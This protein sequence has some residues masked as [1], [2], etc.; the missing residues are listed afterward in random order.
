MFFDNTR[1]AFR[2]LKGY[3]KGIKWV[4]S[5]GTH[6]LMIIY[7]SL[8]LAFSLGNLVANAICL[9]IT[10]AILITT[11]VF[12]IGERKWTE[13]RRAKRKLRKAKNWL[14]AGKILVS[15]YSLGVTLYGMF[16]AASMVSP[17][18]I[19]L[20]TLLIIMWVVNLV[21][22]ICNV[23]ADKLID[24]FE[25]S[26]RKDL[27]WITDSKNF[28][29]EKAD[30]VKESFGE[31][32]V[33]AQETIVVVKESSKEWRAKIKNL[34]KKEGKEIMEESEAVATEEE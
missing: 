19:V 4:T 1:D 20:T 18:S 28:V 12:T 10:I 6:G 23:L 30:I 2:K 17:I 16:I 33:K 24:L 31:A 26:L 15:A 14:K 34:F 7:L 22:E 13:R 3:F 5:Y 8:A 11:I 29:S 9:P 27:Q 21:V 25:E 32:K